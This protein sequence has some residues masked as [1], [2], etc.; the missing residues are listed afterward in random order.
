MA[1][2]GSSVLY[3]RNE[4]HLLDLRARDAAAVVAEALPGVQTPL[5]AAAELADNGGSGA[6]LRG[7]LERYVGGRGSGRPFASASLW[8][9]VDGRAV[10]LL[11]VGERSDLAAGQPATAALLL[12]GRPGLVSP[13]GILAVGSGSPRLGDA[14]RLPGGHVEAVGETR[15]PHDRFAAIGPGSAFAGMR[16]ALYLGNRPVAAQLLET[17]QRRLPIAGPSSSAPVPFG[18]GSLLLVVSSPVPLSSSFFQDLR[19]YAAAL[20]TLLSL[21]VALQFERLVRERALA[22]DNAGR[23]LALQRVSAALGRTM[24]G[25]EIVDVLTGLAREV[26]GADAATLALVD[27]SGRS[28]TV[29]GAAGYES[30]LA[31][32]LSAFPLD[33]PLP[34][35]EGIRSRETVLL[36]E[37]GDWSRRG[38]DPGSVQHPA[39]AVL[40]LVSEG[41][42]VG[43][44]GLSFSQPRRF[45]AAEVA[46]LEAMGGHFSSAIERSRLYEETLA[47]LNERSEVAEVLQSSLLPPALPVVPGV[48]L[49]ARYR[50]A[51]VAAQVGGDFYDVFELSAGRFL[52]A[53]GDVEGR[54][55]EAAAVTGLVRHSLRSLMLAG[56]SPS[57]ALCH[58]ND[59]LLADRGLG[60]FC[61]AAAGVLE[62][63]GDRITL[64]LGLAGHPQPLLARSARAA[65]D[66]GGPWRGASGGL[67]VE[68]IGATGGLLG[69]RRGLAVRD[70]LVELR[71]GDTL[72]WYSD[73]VTERRRGGEFFGEQG[74]AAALGRAAAGDAV[75]VADALEEA[76]RD[77]SP[78]PLADD[79]AILVVS[80]VTDPARTAPA[81][82]GGAAAR[83]A[84]GPPGDVTGGAVRREVPS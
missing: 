16:Y 4:Q 26:V 51:G 58:V 34:L 44:I 72:V 37:P 33:S 38:V 46:F 8:R 18:S 83:A 24:S 59:L 21:L 61:S 40:P 31:R 74:V 11:D 64:L 22:D 12:G 14:F 25:A 47:F 52:L 29:A 30:D 66:A 17:N 20:G 42:G 19:W 75:A 56:A 27:P 7:L 3:R 60:R 76:V 84:A 82:G 67:E 32:E 57:E 41:A 1:A 55:V 15:L 78:V 5:T 80:V 23:L 43:A 50:P 69:V 39:S 2:G 63:C 48:Q 28:V 77:F 9:V 53:I 68:P 6:S 35:A 71:P 54:G 49:A 73:G 13:F 65:P 36:R 62:V 10:E 45:D 70:R 79:L 81:A